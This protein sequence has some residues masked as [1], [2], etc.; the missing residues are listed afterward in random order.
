MF[1][2]KKTRSAVQ[3]ITTS[4]TKL[5]ALMHVMILYETQVM[6]LEQTFYSVIPC[7]F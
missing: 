2:Y 7:S 6:R 1:I 3:Q 5:T 4:Q